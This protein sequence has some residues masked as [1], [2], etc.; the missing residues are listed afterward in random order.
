MAEFASCW[1][2][3]GMQYSHQNRLSAAVGERWGGG[4]VSSPKLLPLWGR[5]VPGTASLARRPE[6][7][8]EESRLTPTLKQLRCYKVKVKVRGYRSHSMLHVFT[9]WSHRIDQFC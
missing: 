6:M 1:V 4:L 5:S 9:L 3:S 7:E 8:T 2:Q